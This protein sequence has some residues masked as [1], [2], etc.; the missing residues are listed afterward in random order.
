MYL[1]R[2]AKSQPG[3]KANFFLGGRSLMNLIKLIKPLNVI[4][5]IKPEAD[6]GGGGGGLR[7]ATPPFV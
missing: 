6:P 2:A 7:A 4:T 5:Y 3:P 1:V